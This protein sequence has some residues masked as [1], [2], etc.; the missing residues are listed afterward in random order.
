VSP[1]A[2]AAPLRAAIPR[3]RKPSGVLS[4]SADATSEV[5]ISQMCLQGVPGS[6]TQHSLAD[7]SRGKEL[8]RT[9]L[10]RG[11]HG[12]PPSLRRPPNLC[13]RLRRS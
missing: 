12:S 9:L 3:S 8:Q 11:A 4:L 6:Q 7:T 10:T 13:R 1:L 5:M 2:A